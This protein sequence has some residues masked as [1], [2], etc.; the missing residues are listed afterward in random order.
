ML[1]THECRELLL[2]PQAGISYVERTKSSPTRAKSKNSAVGWR[3]HIKLVQTELALAC[4]AAQC[5]RGSRLY[6]SMGHAGIGNLRVKC[7][8]LRVARVVGSLATEAH[9][10]SCTRST[11]QSV[12]Y[13]RRDCCHVSLRMAADGS[14]L[15]VVVMRCQCACTCSCP[16]SSNLRVCALCCGL[17]FTSIPVMRV[18]PRE[19]WDGPSDHQVP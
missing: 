6:R 7:G 12:R 9:E 15:G 18:I 4:W 17:S 1:A 5:R 13:F 3:A 16:V 14:G 11:C 10:A 8:L 2:H 19:L